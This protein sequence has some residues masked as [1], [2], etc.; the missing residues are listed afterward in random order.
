ML[1]ETDYTSPK[2]KKALYYFI[3]E[4]IISFKTTFYNDCYLG[5]LQSHVMAQ[6]LNCRWRSIQELTKILNNR[7]SLGMRIQAT[8]ALTQIQ[9]QLVEEE[10]QE[11]KS[12]V[13]I[14]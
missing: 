8:D 4:L 9:Q 2:A 6:R 10:F 14:K 7:K 12:K 11:T 1:L 3:E 5:L 13:D